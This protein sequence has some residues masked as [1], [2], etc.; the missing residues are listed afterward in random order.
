MKKE[1]KKSQR[2]GKPGLTSQ[3]EPVRIRALAGVLEHQGERN[4]PR[5]RKPPASSNRSKPRTD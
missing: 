4:N 1:S 3:Y 5:R 2:R